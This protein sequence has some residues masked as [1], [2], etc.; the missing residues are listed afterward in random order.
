M[1]SK[2]LSLRFYIS[3]LLEIKRK[4]PKKKKEKNR[5]KER[6]ILEWIFFEEKS[7]LQKFYGRD[8]KIL[9]SPKQNRSHSEPKN[10][11]IRSGLVK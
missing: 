2:K 7:C 5:D 9:I 8:E 1:D 4:K 3:I 6:R 10:I 11:D